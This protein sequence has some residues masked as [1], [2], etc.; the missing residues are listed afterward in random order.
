MKYCKIFNLCW[1]LNHI[2]YFQAIVLEEADTFC[3]P[4]ISQTRQIKP[5]NASKV[6]RTGMKFKVR[7]PMRGY[8]IWA[9]YNIKGCN[10]QIY[11]FFITIIVEG[12]KNPRATSLTPQGDLYPNKKRHDVKRQRYIQYFWRSKL[13]WWFISC[14]SECH[15]DFIPSIAR[16]VEF[17]IWNF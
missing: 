6:N 16:Q 5:G 13:Y 10:I 17:C 14:K 11:P 15:P 9:T 3:E 7:I 2:L 4:S 8:I 1:K 12:R